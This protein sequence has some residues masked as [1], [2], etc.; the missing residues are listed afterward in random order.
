MLWGILAAAS[1]AV[2]GA[3]YVTKR[4]PGREGAARAFTLLHAVFG[5]LLPVSAVIHA[6]RACRQEK[7]GTLR[8][9]TGAVLLS[10]VGALLG[11]HFASK[12]LGPVWLPLHRAAAAAAGAAL[13]LHLLTRARGR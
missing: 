5:A 9:V 12:K 10:A 1:L 11:T 6:V 8:A 13:P 7:P 3:N 2:C 4:L